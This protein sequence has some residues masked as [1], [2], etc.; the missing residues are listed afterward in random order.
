MKRLECV[1]TKAKSTAIRP[2]PG[3]SVL[4]LQLYNKEERIRGDKVKNAKYKQQESSTAL[5]DCR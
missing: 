1:T 5:E 2:G 4:F 3:V